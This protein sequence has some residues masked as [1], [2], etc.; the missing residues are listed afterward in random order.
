MPRRERPPET[1]ATDP[2]SPRL[3]GVP[4]PPEEREVDARKVLV[5]QT[6]HVLIP[7][8]L[9]QPAE[10]VGGRLPFP[11]NEGLDRNSVVEALAD[12]EQYQL[13]RGLGHVH[14]CLRRPRATQQHVL[15]R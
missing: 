15:H 9:T 2:P 7:G 8:S 12:D 14:P 13:G 5:E 10:L 4:Q 11:W 6:A 1:E 3:D